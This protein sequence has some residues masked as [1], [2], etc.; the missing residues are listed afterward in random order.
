QLLSD[1]AKS[2]AFREKDSEAL[3]RAIREEMAKGN[4]EGSIALV[5]DMEKTFGYKAEADQFKTEIEERRQEAFRKRVGEAVSGVDRLVRD[6]RWADAL[7]E[8]ERLA[9][10]FPESDS[11]KLLPREI[12]MRREAHKKQLLIEWNDSVKRHDPD[13]SIATLTRLDPYLTPAE[14]EAMQETV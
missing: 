12:E 13:E 2:V 8:A 9:E 10:R 6:E 7:R 4:Y 1:R 5:E 14:A 3:R 11:V